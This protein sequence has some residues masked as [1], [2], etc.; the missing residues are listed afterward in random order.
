MSVSSTPF[1]Q[2]RAEQLTR[3][4]AFGDPERL[5]AWG[6]FVVDGLP[7]PRA[8]RWKYTPVA[9]LLD[10][11]FEPAPRVDARDLPLPP[12][13]P[14]ATRLVF[15]NGHF[16]PGRSDALAPVPGRSSARLAVVPSVPSLPPAAAKGPAGEPGVWALN[17]A[18]FEQATLVE[19][20]AGVDGGK[21]ELLHLMTGVPDGAMAHPRA[22]FRLEAGARLT[23]VERFV[24]HSET[25]Y[26]VDAVTDAEL[27]EGATLVHSVVQSEGTKAL[28]LGTLRIHQ[29]AKSHLESHLLQ[30]GAQL[31]RR[32]VSVHFAGE[33]AEA[34]LDGLFVS[35]GRQHHDQQVELEH[36]QP[37]CVSRQRF[38]GLV[39]GHARGV[40]T[41]RVHVHPDAQKTDAE[42]SARVLLLSPDAE[43]DLRPHLEIHADDVKA[44]H[45]ATVGELDPEQLFYLRTRGIPEATA[46]ELL[47]TAFAREVLDALPEPVLREQALAEL[48]RRAATGKEGA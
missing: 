14:G 9:K 15:V 17:R 19:I 25:A 43:A 4:G 16:E 47:T 18:L 35:G 44:T 23:V 37:G 42:Q 1:E 21:V 36:A 26:F 22:F 5:A 20:P 27:G 29:G 28:H 24:G 39:S 40:F 30:L 7:A 48:E 31:S 10:R 3:G 8:E 34:S 6:R 13:L 12:P 41:G 2:T 38:R 45:G 33:G 11:P 32:E 46:R